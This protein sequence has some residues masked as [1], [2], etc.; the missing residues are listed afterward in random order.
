MK[1]I[2]LIILLSTIPVFAAAQPPIIPPGCNNPVP[3][4]KNPNCP[5]PVPLT[6]LEWLAV[7]GGIYAIKKLRDK[8]ES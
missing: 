7:A 1:H 5:D 3:G 2:L 4:V 6:G 8:N